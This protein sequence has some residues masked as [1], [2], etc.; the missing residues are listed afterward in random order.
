MV[1]P[2]GGRVCRRPSFKSLIT[3]V[4][5]LFFCSF[6]WWIFVLCF[7]VGCFFAFLLIY[8]I[9]RNIQTNRAKYK[10]QRA[11]AKQQTVQRT[12]RAKY[13]EQRAKAKQQT[14]QPT[15]AESQIKKR[16]LNQFKRRFFIS[17]YQA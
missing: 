1:L 15:K 8:L 17:V 2:H 5:R 14:V 12:N 16:R 10:G 13:K 7:F 4:V 6:F 9:N 11:K 3:Q